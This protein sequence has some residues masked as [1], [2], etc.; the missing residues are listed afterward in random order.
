MAGHIGAAKNV[1]RSQ[2]VNRV[3]LQVSLAA[4]VEREGK[5]Y[6]SCCPAISVMSQGETVQK[7]LDNLREA[8]CLFLVSCLERKVLDDVLLEAGFVPR[9]GISTDVE[10]DAEYSIAVPM[11]LVANAKNKPGILAGSC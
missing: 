4:T 2:T 9:S 6:V 3:Q 1:V 10:Q 5:F 11:E 8:V 7:S